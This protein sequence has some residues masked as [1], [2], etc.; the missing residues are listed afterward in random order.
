MSADQVSA[1]NTHVKAY[2]RNIGKTTINI[3]VAYVDGEN[4]TIATDPD[5]ILEG[6]VKLIEIAHPMTSGKT[7]EVKLIAADNTQLS[8]SVKAD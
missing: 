4:A 6:E 1:N 2:V 5:D 7:Y 8:F 3:D